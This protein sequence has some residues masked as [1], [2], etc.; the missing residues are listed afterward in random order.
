[1]LISLKRIIRYSW[2]SFKR[3]SSLTF[4]TIFIM[5]MTISLIS[6]LFLFHHVSQFLI[7]QAQEKVDFSI[8]F[9]EG[10]LEED[11]L[12]VREEILKLPEVKNVEYIS[13]QE[14]VKRL[15]ER[16]P[17][18]KESVKEVEAILNL[19]SLNVRA[20][21]PAQYQVIAV[22]LDKTL[23][24][25]LKNFIDKVDYPQRELIIERIFKLTSDI[26]RFLIFLSLILGVIAI[27][28][29]FNQIRLAI[30]NLRR[31]IAIQRLVGASNW[32]IRGPFLFQGI[33]SG[34]LSALISILILIS[35]SWGLSPKIAA[36]FPEL[37]IFH[38][39]LNNFWNLVLLQLASGIGLGVISS[40]IA[41]RRY[42]RV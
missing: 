38:L 27:L 19:A 13:H 10:V 32:F 4:A 14:A 15:L 6:F 28:V 37:N 31:E 22:F 35:V 11:I 1:M 23:N 34:I 41:I 12:K 21:T 7:A 40:F 33:I 20:Q 29:A 3:Q 42:L 24:P 8:Y 5:V 36:L 2:I 30:Y 39:F 9:K 26:N 25:A 18:L 17:E 16:H